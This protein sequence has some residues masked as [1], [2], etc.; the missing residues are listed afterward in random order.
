[1]IGPVILAA[2]LGVFRGY[3]EW[4]EEGAGVSS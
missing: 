1:V 2:A 3:V 4:R